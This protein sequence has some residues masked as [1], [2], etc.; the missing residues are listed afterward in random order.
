MLERLGKSESFA[1]EIEAGKYR[2]TGKKYSSTMT[3]KILD[4]QKKERFHNRF[5]GVNTFLDF[6]NIINKNK[7]HNLIN[8]SDDQ[9][10]VLFQNIHLHAIDELSQYIED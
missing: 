8:I 4:H 7:I 10:K 5:P 3:L 2:L 9:L 1:P 6:L